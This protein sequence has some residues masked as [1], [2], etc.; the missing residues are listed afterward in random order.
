MTHGIVDKLFKYAP[1]LAAILGIGKLLTL[2]ESARTND[3]ICLGTF[4]TLNMLLWTKFT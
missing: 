4:T 3:V 2:P 1:L